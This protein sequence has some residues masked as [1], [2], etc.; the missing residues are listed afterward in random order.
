MA[1]YFKSFFS[2]LDKFKKTFILLVKHS[3]L[4]VLKLNAY[5]SVILR[6]DFP[7]F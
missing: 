1:C 3:K 5:N 6:H 2:Y 4:S 7:V